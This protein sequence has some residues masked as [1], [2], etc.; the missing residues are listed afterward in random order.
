M[1][2]NTTPRSTRGFFVPSVLNLPDLN[3]GGAG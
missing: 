2:R 1:A 3:G